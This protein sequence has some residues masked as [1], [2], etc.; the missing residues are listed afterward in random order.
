MARNSNAGLIAVA[1]ADEACT[2]KD[3]CSAVL[4]GQYDGVDWPVISAISWKLR[5]AW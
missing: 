4:V 3:D 1:E 5:V 2:E